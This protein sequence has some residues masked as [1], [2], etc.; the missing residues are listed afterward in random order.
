MSPTFQWTKP[1]SIDVQ[2]RSTSH[3]QVQGAKSHSL[4]TA[5]LLPQT[6][7]S[8]DGLRALSIVLVFIAH[9]AGTRNAP[10]FLD[11]LV[12]LGNLGVKVFFVISGFLITTLLLREFAGTGDL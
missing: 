9:A 12:P 10:I 5:P 3:G 1:M 11:Q 6:I 7:P 8:L 4:G 2:T